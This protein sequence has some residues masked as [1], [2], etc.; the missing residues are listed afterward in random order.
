MYIG[1]GVK[2]LFFLSDVNETW[3]FSTDFL[4]MLIHKIS[5]KS[6]QWKPS[7]MRTDMMKLIVAFRSF[8]TV[9][10]KHK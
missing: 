2:Y 6:V 5:W 3:I 10:K 1:H 9:P 4:K 8:A 7:S